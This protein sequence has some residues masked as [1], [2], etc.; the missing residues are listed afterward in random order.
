MDARTGALPK[1]KRM[2]DLLSTNYAEMEKELEEI[3]QE[4]LKKIEINKDLEEAVAELNN[5]YVSGNNT[6]P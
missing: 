3:T 5:L 4:E 2:E 6:D 1:G